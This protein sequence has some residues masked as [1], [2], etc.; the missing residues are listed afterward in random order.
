MD[1]NIE[2]GLDVLGSRSS[3]AKSLRGATSQASTMSGTQHD[4]LPAVD[5]FLGPDPKGRME[6]GSY[7]SQKGMG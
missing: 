5:L 1:I 6:I 4:T 2:I 3:S 7:L